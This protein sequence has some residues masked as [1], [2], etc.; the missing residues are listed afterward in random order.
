MNDDILIESI[1]VDCPICDTVHMVEKRQRMTQGF[2][3][4]EVINF[5]EV[6]FLC[7]KSEDDNE[8]VPGFILEQNLMSA[9]NK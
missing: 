3:N 9:K 8:F 6:Y 4:G 5:Y 2:V 7:D 1:L